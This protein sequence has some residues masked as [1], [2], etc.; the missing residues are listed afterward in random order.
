MK[1]VEGEEAAK[2]LKEISTHLLRHT[3]ANMAIELGRALK[4]ISD[5]FDRSSMPT[6]NTVYVQ[7]G[8]R[9]RTRSG[10]AHI[11]VKSRFLRDK[12]QVPVIYEYYLI[13][14]TH[15]VI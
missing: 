7:P 1:S 15:Y 9:I 5:D 11:K 8:L 13:R 10:N 6:T 2:K 14:P 12:L 3:G 4:D